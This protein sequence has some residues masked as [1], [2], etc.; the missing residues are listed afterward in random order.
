LVLPDLARRF[1]LAK[2]RALPLS[3]SEPYSE[4][5]T[6]LYGLVWSE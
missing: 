4:S 1:A 5:F 3:L 2:T 6:N